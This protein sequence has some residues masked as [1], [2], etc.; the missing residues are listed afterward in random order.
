MLPK[1]PITA[2]ITM[3]MSMAVLSTPLD[4]DKIAHGQKFLPMPLNYGKDFHTG[5]IND[6]QESDG[7]SMPHPIHYMFIP[8]EKNPETAPF[9]FYSMGGPGAS[10][11]SFWYYFNG[12]LRRS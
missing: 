5:M 4:W 12:P 10:V 2:V 1:I 7:L 9:L 11:L 8:C 6:K 3:I